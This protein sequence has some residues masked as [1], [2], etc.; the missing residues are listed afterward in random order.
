MNRTNGYHCTKLKIINKLA[1]MKHDA[2]SHSGDVHFA[3][4]PGQV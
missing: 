4:F 3:D 2:L 1:Q